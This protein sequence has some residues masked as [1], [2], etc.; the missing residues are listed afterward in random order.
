MLG[1]RKQLPASSLGFQ[2]SQSDLISFRLPACRRL[3]INLRHSYPIELGEPPSGPILVVGSLLRVLAEH[4]LGETDHEEFLAN[5]P[6]AC[7]SRLLR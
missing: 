7:L 2:S 4:E 6:A 5:H 3:T 1:F